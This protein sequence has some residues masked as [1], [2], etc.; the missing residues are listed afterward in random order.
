M[1]RVNEEQV[2]ALLDK[3]KSAT[4]I[5]G[6][7]LGEMDELIR[8]N[9]KEPSEDGDVTLNRYELSLVQLHCVLCSVQS[10]LEILEELR[11]S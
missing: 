2:N 7:T 5:V 10:Q 11:E 6:S 4:D 8:N 9:F 1:Q 3:A